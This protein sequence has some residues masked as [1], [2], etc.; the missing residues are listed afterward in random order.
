MAEGQGWGEEQ[1][2]LLWRTQDVP[3]S[4]AKGKVDF[5]LSAGSL[6][7]ECGLIYHFR[8]TE[9]SAWKLRGRSLEPAGS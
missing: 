6:E 2:L 8:V 4:P 5:E 1:L 9:F 3:S 7:G